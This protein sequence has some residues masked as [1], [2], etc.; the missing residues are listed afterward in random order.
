MKRLAI[1]LVCACF[2]FCGKD[3]DDN[4]VVPQPN[5][6]IFP[7][8]IGNTWTYEIIYYGQ[9]GYETSRDTA[10]ISVARDTL[11]EGEKWYQMANDDGLI[12]GF[13][14][15]RDDGYWSGWPPGYLQYKYPTHTGDQYALWGDRI[16]TVEDDSNT[17]YI[18]GR[19][20][21][22]VSYVLTVPNRYPFGRAKLS[23]GVGQVLEESWAETNDNQMYLEG[24]M[25]LI[26]Y[27]VH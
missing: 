5:T 10:R 23:P 26:S 18:H 22:C 7:L 9:N 24:R 16:M 8:A 17:T 4:P 14:T 13:C 21:C 3:D 19:Q 27:V 12:G 6:D 2:V 11:I 25:E 1:L 15:V 20:Y